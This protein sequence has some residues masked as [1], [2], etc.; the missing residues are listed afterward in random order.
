MAS[1][2]VNTIIIITLLD[3]D[4]CV[5]STCNLR[6]LY[7]DTYISITTALLGNKLSVQAA[8]PFKEIHNSI[9]T[10]QLSCTFN[11][12]QSIIVVVN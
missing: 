7:W 1:L 2:V 4:N 11:S 10:L 12:S 9:K 6:C 5:I 8:F 3:C